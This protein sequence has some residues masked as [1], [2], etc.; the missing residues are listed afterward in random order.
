VQR[1]SAPPRRSPERV[2]AQAHKEQI[3][4]ALEAVRR[5]DGPE[6]ASATDPDAR[7]QKLRG[8][9]NAVGYN[10]QAAVA[11][12]QPDQS[13]G[14]RGQLLTAVDLTN[15]P[16]DH[17]QL[18]GM[19]ATIEQTTEQVPTVLADTGYFSS[20]T[21]AAVQSEHPETTALMPDGQAPSSAQAYHK[22][23]FTYDPATDTFTCPEGQTLRFGGMVRRPDSEPDARRYR[24]P[25]KICAA[26]PALALCAKSASKGRSVTLR[27]DD[28]RLRAHRA[29]MATDEART[30][31]RQRKAVIEPVFG[32]IK[33]RLDGRQLYL[34]RLAA[35]RAE[36][37]L[38]ATAF[39]YRVVA[40]GLAARQCRAAGAVGRSAL[41]PDPGH[42]PAR[43]GRSCGSS[44]GA[45]RPSGATDRDR[46]GRGRLSSGTAG[47]R[48]GPSGQI[49]RRH[50]N[51]ETPSS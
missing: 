44:G 40:E 26:C 36:W 17:E 42:H 12:V 28:A 9:G 21:L 47:A 18:P 14:V 10:G 32:V 49:P 30:V 8:G 4:D 48:I 35:V 2:S 34:R 20:A 3:T 19:L 51:D 41:K 22:D 50:S 7:L 27:P 25:R 29:Q 37:T 15:A 16:P 1:D 45:H 13:A 38:L 24:A 5:D 33:E 43:S 6:R 31:Y 23:H 46:H 11:G 39:N